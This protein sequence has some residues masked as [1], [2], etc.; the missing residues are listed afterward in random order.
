MARAV[1]SEAAV[2]VNRMAK[3]AF[4]IEVEVNELIETAA[5]DMLRTENI[6]EVNTDWTEGFSNS[7]ISTL[8][9]IYAYL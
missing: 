8:P 2:K 4:W 7:V 5:V 6:A 9:S 3:V 1:W